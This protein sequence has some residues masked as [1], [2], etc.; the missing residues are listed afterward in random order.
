VGAVYAT[1]QI[2]KDREPVTAA[3]FCCDLVVLG[4]RERCADWDPV[5]ESVKRRWSDV[6]E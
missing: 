3:D 4:K 2:C 5:A 1:P 6:F